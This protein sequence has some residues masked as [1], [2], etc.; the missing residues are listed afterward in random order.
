MTP[1]LRSDV[2]VAAL[3]RAAESRG[4]FVT[5]IA[6]GHEEAGMVHVVIRQRGKASLWSEASAPDGSRGWRCRLADTDEREVD[7]ACTK[8]RGFDPDLWII[9]VEGDI[10]P[11]IL[12]GEILED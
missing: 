5:V 1:R 9:E 4:A 8:E 3:R 12:P 10:T 11:D 7:E 6:R 2:I